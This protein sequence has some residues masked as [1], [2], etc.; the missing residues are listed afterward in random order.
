MTRLYMK[1]ALMTLHKKMELRDEADNLRYEVATEFFSVHD[2]THI[3]NA[4]G[5]TIAELHKKLLSLHS[6]YFVEMHDGTQ[7]E[8][9]EE[10][11]HLVKDV[12]DIKK[13]GW[14]IKGNF[15]EHDYE[16]IDGNGN[17]LASTHRK[18]LSV[19]EA[20]E[21]EIFDESQL[22]TIVAVFVV[23]EHILFTRAQNKSGHPAGGQGQN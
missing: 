13:M 11:F 21:I 8:M 1:Q 5:E 15:M 19:H 18:W 10:L 16:I 9:H 23:L 3:K 17:I 22:E 20:Y 7:F 6:K 14:T 2:K 4:D 12:I